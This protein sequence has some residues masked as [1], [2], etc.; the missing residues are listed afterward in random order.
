MPEFECLDCG[1]TFEGKPPEEREES[2]RCG[3]CNSRDV[4]IRHPGPGFDPD[5]ATGAG[6]DD[7][8]E[9]LREALL[10]TP[11]VGEQGAEYA[12]YWFDHSVESAEDL[13]DVLL[14]VDGV[15]QTVARRIVDT[16]YVG[17]GAGGDAPAY[18]GDDGGGDADGAGESDGGA[19]DAI[20]KAKQA[21]L[22]GNDGGDDASEVARAVSEAMSPALRQ[23]SETQQ[24]LAE[25]MR[26]DGA[27]GGGR[28]E[29]LKGEVESLRETLREEQRESEIERLEQKIEKVE[30]GPVSDEDLLRLR[31]TR[32]ML[33]D[34]PKTSAEAAG[35]WED[36]L[37]GL[38]DR[39]Q[40]AQQ[41]RPLWSPEEADARGAGREGRS[42][43][44]YRPDPGPG[45]APETAASA[46]GGAGG[47]GDVGAGA[48]RVAAGGS[49]SVSATSGDDPAAQRADD[50]PDASA[51]ETTAAERHGPDEQ[52]ASDAGERTSAQPSDG[53]A[54]PE[55][56]G[57]YDSTK[58]RAV[59]M[60]EKL[61]LANGEEVGS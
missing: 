38:T 36:I 26:D 43:P 54:G 27:D 49:G 51:P 35:A 6:D 52:D 37:L 15:D 20:I 10:A 4:E 58:E 17:D 28:V 5:V 14:D 7:T 44:T 29:E 22:I 32:S 30:G 19:L 55:Q 33:E 24:M 61:G 18:Y 42:S 39:L 57:P 56:T 31:E 3:S 46:S 53:G 45:D 25:A 12:V 9:A 1:H 34:L 47:P 23:M 21:G 40:H 11:G 41:N 13:H 2:A 59:E 48:D 50:D 60:R 8:A 16:V